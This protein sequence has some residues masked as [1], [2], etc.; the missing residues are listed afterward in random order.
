MAKI[1]GRANV[2]LKVVIELTED[3]A[4]KCGYLFDDNG[5]DTDGS[6][7]ICAAGEAPVGLGNTINGFQIEGYTG[8]YVGVGSREFCGWSS[9]GIAYTIDKDVAIAIAAEEEMQK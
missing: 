9:R 8:A 1:V 3:E 6:K 4:G 7:Y 2:E 5:G